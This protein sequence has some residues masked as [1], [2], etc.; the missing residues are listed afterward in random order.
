MH[1]HNLF[2]DLFNVRIREGHSPKE[3]FLSECFAHVL[4]TQEKVCQI[5]VSEICE[6]SLN[7]AK[8][9]VSTRYSETDPLKNRVVFPDLR[10][11]ATTIEGEQIVVLAEHKW[12]SPCSNGQL[13]AYR[14]I[15]DKLDPRAALIFV[16]ARRDQVEQSRKSGQV[17]RSLYWEDV[18]G[19]LQSIAIESETLKDFLDFMK[20]QGLGPVPAVTPEKIKAFVESKI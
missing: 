5:W 6:R 4:R 7:L 8:F 3:N 16:G 11:E 19:I 15:A 12:D 18:Y 17:D 14:R 13:E 2:N 20:A 1:E 10:I 9:D